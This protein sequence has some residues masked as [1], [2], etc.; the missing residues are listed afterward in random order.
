MFDAWPWCSKNET[1]LHASLASTATF[2]CGGC[3]TPDYLQVNIFIRV[4][5]R[6]HPMVGLYDV[7]HLSASS[8]AKRL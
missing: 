2:I 6:S 5:Q 8:D 1:H 7:P 3:A 4:L